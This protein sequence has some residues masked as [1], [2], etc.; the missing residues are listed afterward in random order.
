MLSKFAQVSVGALLGASIFF[1]L[2]AAG[3]TIP[4]IPLGAGALLLLWA[5]GRLVRRRR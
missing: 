4:I 3:I 5:I 2:A 1:V